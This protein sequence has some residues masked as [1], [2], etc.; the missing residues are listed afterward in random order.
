[1][2]LYQQQQYQFPDRVCYWLITAR[3]VQV[4]L[5]LAGLAVISEECIS[6]AVPKLW[7]QCGKNTGLAMNPP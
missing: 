5:S 6:A 1:M 7:S 4:I 3:D 2:K